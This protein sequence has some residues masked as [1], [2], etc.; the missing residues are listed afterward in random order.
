MPV[1]KYP[2]PCIRCGLCCAVETCPSG[3]AYYGISKDDPCP[4]FTF[5]SEGK[6]NCALAD[7]NLV[8]IG[9]GCCMLARCLCGDVEVDFA[10][11]PEKVK[12]DVAQRM[13][14]G[15]LPWVKKGEDHA[16]L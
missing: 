4:S 16:S 12:M 14:E 5:N 13:R 11:L 9:D 15:R 10:G 6:A 8:P 1:N 3:Q 2:H 7:L